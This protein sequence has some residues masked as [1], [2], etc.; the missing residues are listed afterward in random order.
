MAK[1]AVCSGNSGCMP[2]ATWWGVIVLVVGILFLL[3]DLE[4]WDFWNIQWW[5]AAFMLMGIWTIWM[6]SAHH[7]KKK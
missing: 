1:K 7:P 5:T 3:R 6:L 4:V 2:C